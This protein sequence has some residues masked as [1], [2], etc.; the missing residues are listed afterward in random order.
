VFKPILREIVENTDGALASILMGLDGIAVE[1]YARPQTH[2]EVDVES[3]G[4]EYSQVLP[5]IKQAAQ[6]LE[7]G[8][9]QEIA[10]QAENMVT[11]LR[12][13]NDEYFVALALAPHGNIGKGRFLLRVQ[14]SKLLESL[15]AP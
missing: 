15:L 8:S 13:L 14:A 4:S 2:P 5:Q 7:M 12:L 6:M 10:I 9:A 11:V 3:V 1:S